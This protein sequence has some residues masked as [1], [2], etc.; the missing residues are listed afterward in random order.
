ML[1]VG[2]G[3]LL[4]S[5]GGEEDQ[6]DDGKPVSASAPAD[7]PSPSADPA[8]EQ[9]VALDKLL[10]DSNDSRATV[11]ASVRNVGR[12]QRLGQS[13]KDLR[14]AAEQRNGLVTRLAELKV[15]KLPA[16][17]RLTA[18]LNRAWKA[19]ASAD[20]HYAVWADQVAGKK[21]CHK[22]RAAAPRSRPRATARAG[23]R[24][25]PRSRPRTTGTRSPASTASPPARRPS[26]RTPDPE[27]PACRVSRGLLQRLLD[28]HEALARGDEPG[29][30]A[31]SG[32]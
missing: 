9:A 26:S 15:D 17:D 28:V 25:P 10:A 2:A 4:S 27:Q 12:C 31:P 24:P 5:G 8:K 13:A 20:N 11:I 14:D 23:R 18:S 16:N 3:A 30:R 19:S 1:G 29:R 21:G 6:A 32:T 22:G 7:E